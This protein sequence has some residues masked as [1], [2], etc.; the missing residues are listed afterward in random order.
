MNQRFPSRPRLVPR[1]PVR[2]RSRLQLVLVLIAVPLLS[3]GLSAGIFWL[4]KKDRGADSLPGTQAGSSFNTSQF[5]VDDPTS[6]WVVVNKQRPLSPPNYIP[7]GL[8]A[9]NIPL[10]AGPDAEA[11]QLKPEAASA[12]EQLTQDAKNDGVELVLVSA[13]RSYDTQTAVYNSE[14]QG[15]GQAVADT[16][17]ARPGHSE[18]QTGWAADLGAVNGACKI[19]ACFADTP[20]GQW[21]A[22]NAYRYGFIIRY[23]PDKTNVTGYTYE[24]WHLRYV[25]AELA[26]EMH[27]TGVQTLEEFF[28]L[29]PAPAY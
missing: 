14:V 5:S 13:Y 15:Y 8:V 12:L 20:E 26:A 7:A 25:G 18:H 3:V 21:L 17:S 28:G 29:P 1:K 2:Q 23:A 22:A 27:R 16:Q 9:P 6:P 10:E 11:M 19:E 4:V 24:P